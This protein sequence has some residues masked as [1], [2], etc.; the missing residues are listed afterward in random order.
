M[1][2]LFDR[3]L[4]EEEA[5]SEQHRRRILKFKR[6]IEPAMHNGL[7]EPVQVWGDLTSGAARK[8][9]N[10]LSYRYND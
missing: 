9:F 1:A 3:L 10:E 5:L 2:D 8:L 6:V 7:R 4:N